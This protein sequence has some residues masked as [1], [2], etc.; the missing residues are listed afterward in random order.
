V[1]ITALAIPINTYSQLINKC[2]ALL[3]NGSYYFA[4]IRSTDLFIKTDLNFNVIESISVNITCSGLFYDN[5]GHI[6]FIPRG[7]ISVFNRFDISSVSIFKFFWSFATDTTSSDHTGSLNF[8]RIHNVSFPNVKYGTVY[9][10]NY[11]VLRI[12]NGQASILY[13]T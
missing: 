10:V 2:G 7:D 5:N 4:P 3:F 6:F 9:A 13:A 1:G 11:N 8:S 12:K